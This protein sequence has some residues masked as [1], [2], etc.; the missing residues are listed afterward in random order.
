M[1]YEGVMEM[2]V[3]ILLRMLQ[4]KGRQVLWICL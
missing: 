4:R 1:L 3:Q 2:I